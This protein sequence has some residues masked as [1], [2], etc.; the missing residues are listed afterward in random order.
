MTK[1]SILIKKQ[2]PLEPTRKEL[3][4]A[5][6][7]ARTITAQSPIVQHSIVGMI[8]AR[9]LYMAY[10]S[11]L[12]NELAHGWEVDNL[13]LIVQTIEMSAQER[14]MIN[15]TAL[16]IQRDIFQCIIPT[17]DIIVRQEHEDGRALAAKEKENPVAPQEGS[18]D[19]EVTPP[20]PSV[21]T[22]IT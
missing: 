3:E 5:A 13:P 9:R 1:K 14:A 15:H 18:E 22:A 20:E 7:D 11:M 2:A 19:N 12:D 16:D 4:D 21:D 8:A 17:L 6:E 10:R